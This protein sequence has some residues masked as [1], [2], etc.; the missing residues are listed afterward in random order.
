[1]FVNYFFYF[2]FL[3]WSKSKIISTMLQ[4]SFVLTVLWVQTELKLAH[5]CSDKW[6]THTKVT[7]SCLSSPSKAGEK[8]NTHRQTPTWG[9]NSENHYCARASPCSSLFAKSAQEQTLIVSP[10]NWLLKLLR[11]ISYN[12]SFPFSF[13]KK[14]TSCAVQ[15][16]RNCDMQYTL[17]SPD[18]GVYA[19]ACSDPSSLSCI[20]P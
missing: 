6:D 14:K 3:T 15:Q 19:P 1:M 8:T 17:G 4:T 2:F 9:G 12:I 13:C 18:S 10:Q 16:K 7:L 20:H 5:R 11:R